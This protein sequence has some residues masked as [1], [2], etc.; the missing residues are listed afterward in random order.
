[1][2]RL[3]ILRTLTVLVMLFSVTEVSAAP[4]PLA[5]SILAL[6]AGQLSLL[7]DPQH[8]LSWQ[9]ALSFQR[10]GHFEPIPNGV[11]EG[12][13]SSA[14]WVYAELERL[15]D[16]PSFWGFLS[17][18]VYLDSVEYYLIQGGQLIHYLAAGDLNEDPEH[19]MHHR[20]PIVGSYI[21][22]GP[23][24][25]L[26]RL[27]TS[28]TS[29]LLIQMVPEN[30]IQA[31][32]QGR[33]LNEGILIGILLMVLLI[34]LINGIWLRRMLF[35]YFVVYE[36]SMLATILLS[37]GFIRDWAPSVSAA[38]Q[39]LIMQF[40]VLW[41]GIMAFMFFSRLLNFTF[42]AK[43]W[44][45]S[46]FSIGILIALVGMLFT[47]YGKYAFVMQFV[48]AFVS[49][50]P[51]AV[52]IPLLLEWRCMNVE[53]RFRAG[54]F[55]IFGIFVIVN[56]AYTVGFFPV[57]LGTT[58]IAPIMILSFQLSLHFVIM[59]SIRKSESLLRSAQSREQQARQDAEHERSI[60]RSHEM[61]M[62]MFAHEVRTPLAVIDTT[63]QALQRLESKRTDSDQHQPRY[64]RV[65][66]SV[67]RINS[68]LHMSLL[69]DD[70]FIPS[71]V[72]TNQQYRLPHVIGS[73][74]LNFSAREQ[75]RINI[76]IPF[77]KDYTGNI[78]ADVLSMIL[79]NLID[80]A[81]KYSPAEY[82]VNVR[83][84]LQ[85]NDLELS[86]RDSG[87][88]LSDRVRSRM[89]ER[90]FR[91][92]EFSSVPGLGLGLFVVK[93]VVDRFKGYIDVDTG[94]DGTEIRIRLVGMDA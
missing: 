72:S 17:S 56:C 57:T 16:S 80:N 60:R 45:N 49:L 46:L 54:G 11:G 10:S 42:R 5:Q 33:I 63:T 41:T 24:E 82:P 38:E 44:V 59:F 6:D 65:R 40:S 29:V 47:Y 34:N 43:R 71:G 50:F 88:G 9:Q 74:L 79:R 27:E 64:Q 76:E 75:S 23:V 61:F 84:S 83:V 86:V 15:P 1:M 2:M 87:A 35:V 66:D 67:T 91:A 25:L 19:D 31:V 62:D 77:D 28:S 18:P 32:I 90:H 89:F 53:Q 85:G 14:F 78:P 22:E 93:E 94:K 21:P 52:S 8:E 92:N 68:L 3:Y 7:E 55:F 13:T 12:Y 4:V 73:L 30:R 70:S 39:N 36:A 51:V 81:L 58:Y 48:N 37:N 20:L 26:V 69:R